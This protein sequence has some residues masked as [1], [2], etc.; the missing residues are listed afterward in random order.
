MKN[1]RGEPRKVYGFVRKL[2]DSHKKVVLVGL[3]P[4]YNVGSV[5]LSRM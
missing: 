2:K 3:L 4:K 1:A 5:G